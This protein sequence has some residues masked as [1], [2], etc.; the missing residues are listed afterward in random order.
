MGLGLLGL[1]TVQI[2]QAYGCTVTAYDPA[3]DKVALTKQLGVK[4]ATSKVTELQSLINRCTQA[5]GVDSVIIRR[6]L[7]NSDL[8]YKGS[9]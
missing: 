7:L 4:N 3:E 8:R 2:L 1:L 9:E 6:S 5:R